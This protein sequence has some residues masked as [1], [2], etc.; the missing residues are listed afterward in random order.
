MPV[1]EFAEK[2]GLV[3][4]TYNLSRG[5]LAQITGLDKS[6]VSRWASGATVPSDHNL[7]LLTQAVARHKP[8]FSRADWDLDGD[9]FARR[10]KGQASSSVEPAAERPA[11][12]VLPFANPGGVGDEEY[13]ADGI[14][15]DIITALSKFR[16][17]LVIARNSSF[18]YRGRAVDMR[19][20]GR[21]LGVRYIVEGSVRRAANRVR[22]TAQLSEAESGTH[23]WAERYD[24]DLADIFGIQDR[25][26]A[27][28]AVAIEP[29]VTQH[30]H[31]R[32][33]NRA[34]ESLAAWDLLLRGSWHFHQFT[35]EAME[36][37]LDCYRRAVAVDPNLADAH[38]GLS[39]VLFS[40]GIY[41]FRRE[42]E[43]L[44][45]EAE[46][47]SRRGLA[48]DSQNALAYFML[49]LGASHRGDAE[50]A[51]DHSRQ[52]LRLNPNL[53]PAWF[54]LAVAS[55]FAGRPDEA[56]DAIDTALR[57]SPC[58]PFKATWL[59]QRAS[60][61]YLSKRYEEAVESARQSMAVRWF[62]TACRVMAASYGQLGRKAEAK[63]AVAQLLAASDAADKSIAQV[64]R[65][66]RRPIDRE[67]YASGLRKAGMPEN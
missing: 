7:S 51:A 25:V 48:L 22:I 58:D 11:I 17:F 28:V 40:L 24:G 30:E 45:G 21:E 26:T 57:L 54:S 55:S 47:S 13:F 4:K 23:L 56:L 64:I 5:R 46:A 9:A 19:Q 38:V 52:A 6:V 34:P 44:F 36:K 35:G 60:A 1:A 32:S 12:A 15:E 33:R 41:G 61:L 50:T 8:D 42:R 2:L 65:L 14:T 16:S 29:A 53:S 37:A 27:S 31:D 62:H 39:R 3:L 67:L 63:A 49:S 20:I 59:A 10:L 18:T 66:F 43:I